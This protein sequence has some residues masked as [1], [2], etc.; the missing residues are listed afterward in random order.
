MRRRSDIIWSIVIVLIVAVAVWVVTNPALP[1]RLGLD[2]QGGL[3]VL[4]EADVPEDVEVTAEAMDTARQIID[5]RVNAI[6]VTEP[7]VQ[8]EGARRILIE[9]PGIE[10]P[11]EALSLIQ[12]TAL[13]EFVDTGDQSLPAGGCIFPSPQQR[14]P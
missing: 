3:Q 8:V 6:G 5:R 11:Q 7:L 4:L 13:L 9:L 14:Q 1:I 10:D 2:L 12:E